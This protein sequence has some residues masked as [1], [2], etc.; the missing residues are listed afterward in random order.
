MPTRYGDGPS[1]MDW[2]RLGIAGAGAINQQREQ[3]RI[4][5]ARARQEEIARVTDAIMQNPEVDINTLSQDPMVR[6]GAQTQAVSMKLREYDK[7]EAGK[8]AIL[9]DMDLNQKKLTQAYSAWKSEPEGKRKN[10]L[11]IA[12]HNLTPDG[13]NAELTKD[14]V[15]FTITETGE[16][17][18][19]PLPDTAQIEEG[20]MPFLQP[21]SFIQSY[22]VQRQSRIDY[23]Q[24]Q[25]MN[26]EP[27]YNK[28]GEELGYVNQFIDKENGRKSPIYRDQS[29]AK[30][31]KPKGSKTKEEWDMIKSQAGEKRAAETF[32][33]RKDAAKDKPKGDQLIQVGDKQMT[34]KQIEGEMKALKAALA[35]PKGDKP[36]MLITEMLK[37]DEGDLRT[38]LDRLE[39]LAKKASPRS[40]EAAQRY[41]ELFR[42]ITGMTGEDSKT[43][44]PKEVLDSL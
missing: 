11:A 7:T 30:L 43:T 8:K 28:K 3:G 4:A 26:P 5:G 25:L 34:T 15:R 9:S 37:A 1:G 14:G 32:E 19:R 44:T 20:I 6:I 33:I 40:K 22:A 24:N 31:E 18:N 17:F 10:E 39:K 21:Q 23:N 2:A 38:E 35:P 13:K 36:L 41:L 42:A 16:A 12:M 27:V 29:G